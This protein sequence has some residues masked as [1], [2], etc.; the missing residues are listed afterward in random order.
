MKRESLSAYWTPPPLLSLSEWAARYAY[1]P[2]ETSAE[3]GKW[4]AY[5]Y[6]IGIM[7]AISDPA[8]E[9]VTV[10]KSRR[11]GYTKIINHLIGYSIHQDPAPIL[12]VQPTVEDAEDYGKDELEPMFRDVPAVG[13]LVSER[14]SRNVDNTLAR[15]RF[16]GGQLILVGANAPRGFR[17]V[18]V[19]RVLFDEVDGYPTKGAGVEGDQ[20]ELGI[21]RSDTFA[22]RK[23]VLGSTPTLKGAS[24][25]EAS[26]AQSDQRYYFV[27]CPHCHAMQV[28]QWER[29]SWPPGRPEAV[30][31]RC[32]ACEALIDYSHQRWMVEHGEWRASAPFR[33]HAGF[34]IWAAY[35]YSPHAAW[36]LLAA[37]FEEAARLPTAMRTFVNQILGQ[38]YED[39]G[40]H[41]E[42]DSLMARRE[43]WSGRPEGVLTTTCGVD[44]QGDRLELELVGW[45][46]DEESWSLDYRVIWGDPGGAQVWRELA[47][48]L[49]RER[50]A[51][52]CVDSGGHH[53]EQVYRFCRAQAGLRVFAIKGA[54][55]AG[56][57]VWPR[58]A[59][60]GKGGA[61]V[62]VIGVDAAKDMI[63]SHLRVQRPGP[64]YCHFPAER[65]AAY[66]VGLTAE[67]VVTRY[68]KGFP[69]REYKL[70]PGVRNEPLDCRVYAFAALCS[71]A[72]IDWKG[73]RQRVESERNTAHAPPPA[74]NATLNK[75]NHPAFSRPAT[76]GTVRMPRNWVANW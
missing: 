14:K 54:V 47:A 16:P 6:Q 71:F 15:K 72:R 35:S 37:K 46:S 30:G 69:V 10:M 44:V 12:V 28:L 27:P 58:T 75:M 31:Y 25:I 11:V 39:A 56:R 52:T 51:A 59:S 19:K 55:G 24:R 63:Y 42:E 61:K 32:E 9:R 26:F 64:G 60:R 53:T 5:P 7:D 50:P 40:E 43:R 68:S 3:P 1:L 66:F 4:R 70:R 41:P 18:T 34:H 49:A 2:A 74:P 67:T 73:L 20:I 62:F 17:R 76:G 13:R 36:P 8:V 22:D 33:G 21:G 65:D 29:M 57:P 48:F 23:I 38:P 45:G